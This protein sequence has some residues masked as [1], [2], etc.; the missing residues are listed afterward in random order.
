M[1][2]EKLLASGLDM[3]YLASCA[4]HDASPDPLRVQ[5]MDLPTVCRI[6]EMH[7]MQSIVYM[8]L[9]Q[10]AS[11]PLSAYPE[12]NQ[13]L[14]ISYTRVMQMLVAYDLEREAIFQFF[15]DNNIWYLPLKGAVLQQ[16]YP[17][18]GMR[19]MVDNDILID[20]NGR[21]PLR[22]FMEARGYDVNA[23]G[24][25]VPD[26]YSKAPRVHFEIHHVLYEDIERI[27]R[28]RAYYLDVEKRLLRVGSYERAMSEED[29]YVY[30][31]SHA[32]KHFS[33]SGNGIRSLMDVHVFLSKHGSTLNWTYI[34]H[35]LEKLEIARFERTTR[36]LAEKLFLSEQAEPLTE[37]DRELL[38]FYLSSGTFG[39]ADYAVMGRLSDM[40]KDRKITFGVKLRYCFRR[41]VPSME[42]YKVYHPIV[43]K[44]KILIPGF[45][46]WRLLCA[47]WK[48]PRRIFE[49]IQ[50]IKRTK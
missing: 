15:N 40:G 5:E 14:R 11:E 23:Y 50:I 4:L 8:A 13:R 46:I 17:R 7:S 19:Q 18:L 24:L 26:D 41:L 42:T 36:A 49:E 43:Y 6:A 32:Y 10:C 37:T 30:F 35:E 33:G 2:Q 20:S 3:I 39:R 31:V 12:L 48:S 45:L 27:R 28:F 29:F 22:T 9:E 34:Y 38:L 16:D 1:E 47:L 44:H 25:G 21:A